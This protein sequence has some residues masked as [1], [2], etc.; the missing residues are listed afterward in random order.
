MLCCCVAVATQL[1]IF[2]NA[3]LGADLSTEREDSRV[4]YTAVVIDKASLLGLLCVLW[5]SRRRVSMLG[6][7]QLFFRNWSTPPFCP[8][9][10]GI[11][12]S[13]ANL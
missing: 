2:L 8:R 12:V 5:V 6:A 1:H 13:L 10:R 9:L 11:S 7:C 3:I 4:S